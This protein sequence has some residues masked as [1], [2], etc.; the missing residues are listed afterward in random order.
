MS[1]KDAIL[2]REMHSSVVGVKPD[3]RSGPVVGFAPSAAGDALAAVEDSVG[4]VVCISARSEKR[5]HAVAAS[6]GSVA[7]TFFLLVPD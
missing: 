5:V 7:G 6:A 2:L 3:A 1:A 4:A